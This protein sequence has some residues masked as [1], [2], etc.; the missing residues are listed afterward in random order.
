MHAGSVVWSIYT[1]IESHIAKALGVPVPLV[2]FC[3]ASRVRV[4]AHIEDVDKAYR[5]SSNKVSSRGHRRYRLLH[6]LT[7]CER[8]AGVT[9]RFDPGL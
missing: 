5:E 2:S 8:I 7:D 4:R 6:G 9:Q 3:R 1:L